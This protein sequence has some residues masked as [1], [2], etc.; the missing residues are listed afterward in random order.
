MRFTH[1]PGDRPLDGYT[2]QQGLGRG[3][4]GEVYQAV[5]DGGKQVA[6]KLV[7]RNLEVELRG[8]GQC[9]NLKHPNL[10]AVYDVK[11]AEN[12]DRWIVMEHV[13]GETLDKAL[14]RNPNGLPEAE[15][16]AWLKGVCEGVGY[17]HE[18]GIVHRDLKP[19]NLF[20]ENGCVKIGDYGLSKFISASR[21]SGQTMSIGT[22]HYM[23]PEVVKGRYGKEVDLYA[24]GVILYEMLTG[25][26]PFDGE[27]PGE[28]LMKH[29]TASP[30]LSP[31]PASFRP[32]VARLLD[33]E[34]ARRYSSVQAAW[35]DLTGYLASPPV[36]SI[37]ET[38]VE[39]TPQASPLREAL[40]L[41]ASMPPPAPVRPEEQAAAAPVARWLFFLGA[42]LVSVA[43][44][45]FAGMATY[46]LAQTTPRLRNDAGMAIAIFTAILVFGVSVLWFSRLV[47]TRGGRHARHVPRPR[48]GDAGRVRA[49]IRSG[50]AAWVRLL[51]SLSPGLGAGL[52]LGG[53]CY[54]NHVDDAAALLIGFGSGLA[55]AG[56]VG[57]PL[58]AGG[59]GVIAR[60]ILALALGVGAGLFFGG[61]CEFN[62]MDEEA[63]TLIGFG[64]GLL[65]PSLAIGW[66]LW[67]KTRES[68]MQPASETPS[69]AGAITGL[70][71]HQT[72]PWEPQSEHAR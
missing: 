26:V 35:A 53:V 33:K 34:P 2:I 30:D 57:G 54:F 37:E 7:Q 41:F 16:L 62:R 42:F 9:L 63:S 65:A 59:G 58:L 55:L 51:L 39:G 12:G 46:G 43:T 66:L 49:A 38:P 67:R 13:Q 8:V 31:V 11:Q 4:F 68:A 5:S 18:Q 14:A 19:G 60:F 23:A 22:V 20:M 32:V 21:R 48:L 61:I 45:V 36:T 3:G 6:L 69:T 70:P 25:R 47:R 64:S 24:I 15:V 27:S 10:V 72:G 28:I 29:L 50:P 17:L 40:G 44:T 52:L 71:G 1:G 56:F